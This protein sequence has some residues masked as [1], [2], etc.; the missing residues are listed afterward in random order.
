MDKRRVMGGTQ[1]GDTPE[2]VGH[3]VDGRGTVSGSVGVGGAQ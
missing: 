3:N 2:W 1:R